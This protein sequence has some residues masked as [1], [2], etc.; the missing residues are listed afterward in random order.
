VFDQDCDPLFYEVVV[1]VDGSEDDTVGMLNARAPACGFRFMVQRNAGQASARNRAIHA[2]RGDLILFLD[3]DILVPRNF[4]SSHI[5]AHTSDNATLAFGAVYVSPLSK[6][7]LATSYTESFSKI[8]YGE[9]ENGA[10]VRF[11]DHVHVLP[12]S[13]VP[14]SALLAVD[15]F[16]EAFFRAHEDTEL[17]IRLWKRGFTFR[18]LPGVACEQVF[19]KR[20]VD[21]GVLE[22]KLD[23]RCEVLLCEKHKDYRHFC[24]LVPLPPIMHL[25][26]EC[27]LRFPYTPE[28]SSVVVRAAETFSGSQFGSRIG[29]R[30]MSISRRANLQFAACEVLG[31]RKELREQYW[32]PL[33]VL[34]YHHVGPETGLGTLTVTPAEFAIQM[35]WLQEAG[36]ECIC[37]SQWRSWCEDGTPLPAKPIIITFDDGYADLERYAFP[38]LEG[39]N[40]KATVFVVTG[41]IGGTNNWDRH[42]GLAKS[43]LLNADQ[44]KYWSQK[45]IEFGSHTRTHCDLSKCD[46]D[47]IHREIIGSAD[48]LES[49]TGV[50]PRSFAYP[51]GIYTLKVT[52]IVSRAYGTGFSVN[53]GRNHLGTDYCALKRTMVLARDTKSAFLSRLHIGRS[54]REVVRRFLL[55]GREPHIVEPVQTNELV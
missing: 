13:S 42:K 4:V 7:G 20:A 17:G 36:F 32:K 52:E 9:L 2:A 37:P 3:D 51:Y 34:M 6:R 41:E 31:G 54:P 10:R 55:N 46:K 33:P 18:F 38:I 11:P 49:V 40:M 21:V 44:V 5:A 19:G 25:I 29:R 23:G 43:L 30:L 24:D 47:Q 48:D 45:G 22:S 1:V 27:L 39:R 14:R 35:K 53:D 50:R 12:N 16:D 15:G 26:E 8:Y 28:L